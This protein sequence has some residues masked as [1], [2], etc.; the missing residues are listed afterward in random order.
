MASIIRQNE[1]GEQR[2]TDQPEALSGLTVLEVGGRISAAY[3]SKLLAD[4]GCEV[5]KVEP[6]A[7]DDTRYVG[8]YPGDVEDTERSGLFLHLNANKRSVVLDPAHERDREALLGLAAGA[9]VVIDTFLPDTAG[10]FRLT[11]ADYEA[12]NDKLIVVSVTPFGHTGPYRSWNGYDITTGAFGGICTYLGSEDR[13]LLGAP[14]AIVE[15]QSGLNAAV[16]ALIGV[17]AGAGGQHVDISESDVWATSQNGMGVIEYIYG[18]RAF[19]RIGRGVHGGPYPNTILPCADGYVRAIAIQRRE[20]NRFVELIGKPKWAEDERFQDRVLMNEQ[21]WEELDGHLKA[22]MADKTKQEIFEMCQQAKIPFAPVSTVRDILEDPSF[23]RWWE[24]VDHSVAGP[25]RQSRP[26]YVL[27]ATPAKVR[28]GAPRLGEDNEKLLENGDGTDALAPGPAAKVVS[29]D[30]MA[31]VRVVDFGWAWAGAVCG[32][33]LADFGAEVIKIESRSR[34]DPMRMGRPIV[35]DTPDPEQNPIASNVNRNKLSFTVNLKTQGGLALARKLVAESDVVVENLSAGTVDRLGLGYEDLRAV[36]PDIIMVSL[37]AAGVTGPLKD[38]RS[39]GPTI[40]GLSGLDSLVGYEGE[41]PIGFQQAFGDPNVGMHAAVA[42]LAALRH[43]RRTGIGQFIETG[44]LQTMLPLL[45]E[46]VADYEMNG[47]VAGPV[48]NRRAGFAPYGTYPCSAED[49]WVSIAVHTEDEWVGLCRAIERE[50]L[51]G[52]ER[53]RDIES[54]ARH[55]RV[56]D[57]K[58]AAWT[59]PLEDREAA[60]RLQEAGVAAAPCLGVE[61][62]FFDE[63]LRSREAY[64]PVNHP[65]LGTEFIFGIPWKFSKTPGRIRRRAPMLGEH[66]TYV[67]E[68]VLGLDQSEVDRY[69]EEGVL[70]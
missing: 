27:S 13:Y 8:P 58:I 17:L 34:L 20:W 19:A 37:P 3:A 11:P 54:R 28:K 50:D 67:L 12:V 47:R 48:D 41:E 52:D 59:S 16:A 21:H 4:L 69:T 14:L 53:F 56:L 26:P 36:R 5:I 57:A 51:L 70:E 22:W 2:V 61:A 30:A 25:I 6:P 49:S 68:S 39:Y 44:Q 60:L 31:G 45:G 40:N 23:A 18:G 33:I 32:Q 38:L 42:V 1:R 66:N 24:K 55:R 43:R 29:L 46:A 9:D 15:Y 62:R 64:I 35:G 65:V 7:G 10:R 63:H